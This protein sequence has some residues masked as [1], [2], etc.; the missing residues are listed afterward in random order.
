M[1]LTRERRRIVAAVALVAAG[2]TGAGATTMV[3]MNLDQL[4]AAASTVAR[5][6]C[7]ENHTVAADGSLWTMTT[8]EVVESL[9]GTAP[10]RITVRL[11]GGRTAGASVRVEGVPRFEPG[12]ELYLFLEPNRKGEFTVSG[13][14]QGTFR[15]RRAEGSEIVSQDTG[16]VFLFDPATRQYRPGGARSLPVSEFKQHVRE[17]TERLSNKGRQQ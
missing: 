4:T 14:A 1:F 8:F 12:E 15:V 7:V 6:R 16:G 13:W 17:A 5:V 10:A 2:V 3:R 9:K 11:V